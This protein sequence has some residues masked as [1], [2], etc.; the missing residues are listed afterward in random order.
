MRVRAGAVARR[1]RR[2]AGPVIALGARLRRA[3]GLA[4]GAVVLFRL[5]GPAEILERELPR[6]PGERGI[7]VA[8]A[9]RR[10]ADDGAGRQRIIELARDIIGGPLIAAR[11]GEP[12]VGEQG[13]DR[14][15]TR[16]N[17]SHSCAYRMP[18]SV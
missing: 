18:S 9:E 5:A 7:V 4:I 10:F 3:R 2:A 6:Q 14:K 13:L 15:S 12:R 11:L 16:L 17:S 8:H 1:Q